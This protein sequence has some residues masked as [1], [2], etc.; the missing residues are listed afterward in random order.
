MDNDNPIGI[1]RD[2][3]QRQFSVGLQLSEL[4]WTDENMLA[5]QCVGSRLQCR[6]GQTCRL[7]QCLVG[8]L[9]DPD[10]TRAG[11]GVRFELRCGNL[12]SRLDGARFYQLLESAGA[13][14]DD[15]AVRSLHD[16]LLYSF[17]RRERT[18]SHRAGGVLEPCQGRL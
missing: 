4:L 2:S 17:V 8:M 3:S 1:S 7:L 14:R 10:V 13:E 6:T 15:L 5:R 18:S 9:E 16:D 12:S 11:S